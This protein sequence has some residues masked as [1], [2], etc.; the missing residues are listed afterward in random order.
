MPCQ[1]SPTKTGRIRLYKSLVRARHVSPLQQV[2]IFADSSVEL[3][4]NSKPSCEHLMIDSQCG[5]GGFAP[6][7]LAD[8]LQTFFALKKA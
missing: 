5:F 8:V 6:G 3:H 2:A 7:K 1:G 4:S